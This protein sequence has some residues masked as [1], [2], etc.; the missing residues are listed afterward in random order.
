MS[1][2]LGLWTIALAWTVG[3]CL[4]QETRGGI[5]GRVSDPQGA[6]I[7]GAAV[8]I[9]NIQTNTISRTTT[10]TSGYFEINLLFPGEYSV[11]AEAAGFKKFVRSGLVL[12]VAGRLDIPIQLQV[13]QMAEVVEVTAEAPL[14]D[15][16]TAS[17]GRV[18]DNRQIMQLPFS[19]LNPFVLAGL[20]PG[21]QWTGRPDYRRPFDNNGTSSFNTMGGVGPNEYT[22]DGASNIHGSVVAY[23]P[24]ADAVEEFKLETTPFDASY[25][26]TSGATINVMTKAGTNDFHGSI[27]DQHWQK[28]WNATQHFQRL[29]YENDLRTGKKKPGDEK[30]PPGRQNYYGAGVGGPVWIPKV[31]DGRN[32]LFF[33]FMYSGIM[34]DEPE[35]GSNVNQTVPKMAW[36]QGDFSDMLAIDA[37]KYTIYD[38]RS[39]SRDA[40]GVVRRTP[41]PGNRGIPVL[42]P[43][44]KFYEPLYPKPNDVPGLVSPEGFNNYFASGMPK[45]ERFKSAIHRMDFNINER[46]RVYGRWYW[47]RRNGDEYD[48]TYET[49]RG[50]QSNGITRINKGVGA[51]Y[52]WT[53]GNATILNA[54]VNWGRYADGSSGSLVAIGTS[55][56]P[57]DVG[58]PA[59]LDQKAGEFHRLPGLDFNNISDLRSGYPFIGNRETTGQARLAL[60]TIK[61]NHSLKFGFDERRYWNTRGG[62]GNTSGNFT[63]RNGYMRAADND[64]RSSSH[65]LDWAA[66]MMGVPTGIG[67]DTNDSAY[68]ST[69]WRAAYLQDDW[70]I[71]NRFRVNLGL[72][73]EFEGGI[74]ERFN[75]GLAGGWDYGFQFPFSA[76]VEAAY[77]A[78]PLP[79]LP[80]IQVRGAGSYLGAAHDSYTDGTNHLLP[81]IGVVYQLGNKTVLRTGYGWYY[82]SYSTFRD[83]PNQIGYS[84]G[85]GTV[86]STD[87]GLSFCCGVGAA[88]NL[89]SGRTLLN[90][91]FPVRATGTRFDTPYGNTL[92]PNIFAGRGLDVEPRD[93]AP[94]FQQRWRIGIQRELSNN[95]VVDVSYNGAFARIP[96]LQRIDYLPEQ[97]WATGNTR[98]QDIDNDLNR[99]VPNPFNIRNLGALQQSNPTLYSYLSTVGFFTGSTIRRHQLLRAF[100]QLNGSDGLRPNTEFKD[101]RGKN[102]YH[103]LQ[104]QLDKRFA[105]GFQTTVMYTYANGQE[106]D[107]YNNQ[108]DPMPLVFRPQ[109]ALRPHRFAWTA[110][111]ELP[112]GKGRRFITGG[113]A[114]HILGGWQLSW[115]YQF[116]NGAATGWGN[117]FFY[118]DLDQIGD[119]FQHE[120]VHSKDIHVWFDPNIIYN[121]S[122]AV[123]SNFV[124]F[125]G[126]S[127]MQPGSYHVRMF[128]TR[129]EELRS[130]GIRTWDVKI[131]RKFRL[132]ERA[133]FNFSVDLLNATNHTNFGGPNTDPTNRNFGRVTSTNGYARV[134]QLTGRIEF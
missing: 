41:F 93:Y 25:G 94:A 102:K 125:E 81:R 73:Y 60:T 119:L 97:Y 84:Q 14:L 75:R 71:T 130:D 107:F 123:P 30:N 80:S 16:T 2:T 9:T 32:K 23:V 3:V 108:F 105:A 42:N 116:Q 95:I 64:N 91:P 65:A 22:I 8:T 69:P 98:R 10:S 39:A 45:N 1:K 7:P 87:N 62:P 110:I 48:W 92:G 124:G 56:K 79:E 72:R 128:P 134:I 31:F 133:A 88:A 38:P 15:T 76:A 106:A 126:R 37:A 44:Y 34:K 59:Y 53:I 11:T 90:D 47:N 36:R 104:L 5:T 74:R 27:Y 6:M 78:N 70:R 129:L 51:D 43:M 35:P 82:D 33:Y 67:I 49:K 24:P 117:R 12:N 118:G 111:W 131:L 63:F 29:Q 112:F 58:L 113:P 85:T 17:G 121:G 115:I 20:A 101:V 61:G 52:V 99:N 13:G 127:N 96:V 114:Q 66:F 26:H 132:Y 120:D 55:F 28:R 103:D 77:A 21:M 54:T 122:G 68:W 18:I 89:G 40:N 83:R 109:D 86:I 57:S 4:A 100:P 46:H 19:D 50:L